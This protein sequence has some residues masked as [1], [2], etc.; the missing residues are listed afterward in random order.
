MHIKENIESLDFEMSG[1]D[2]AVLD[3]FRNSEFDKVEVSFK[4]EEGKV[5][6]DQLPNQKIGIL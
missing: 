1:D 2:Y 3:N 6:I 4:T 5:R